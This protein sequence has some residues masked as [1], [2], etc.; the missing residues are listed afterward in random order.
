MWLIIV[1]DQLR[2]IHVFDRVRLCMFAWGKLE[3]VLRC[4]LAT[5]KMEHTE[6]VH[7]ASRS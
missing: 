4:R 6:E 7:R 3:H 5:G 1:K 2:Y